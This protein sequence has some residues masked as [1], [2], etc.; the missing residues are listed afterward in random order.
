MIIDVSKWNGTINWEM[1]KGVIKGAILQCGYGDD[2][3]SQ[4]DPTFIRNATECERL[5]IP[6][7]VYLFS[8]ADSD[9]H[10]ESETDHILRMLKGRNLSYPVYIDLESEG[11]PKSSYNAN[12]F[13]KMGEKIENAGYWFGVYANEDWF[14]TTIKNSLDRFT[15]WIANY[16]RKPA[17]ACD[18]W[19]YTS[20]GNIAGVQGNL[21]CNE[22]YRDFPKEISGKVVTPSKPS[23]T[24]TPTPSVVTYTT[25]SGDS[26]S[27][28]ASKY[29][30]TWQELA[31][32]NGIANPNLIYPGQVIK[33]K[34]AASAQTYVSYTVQK[35]DSLW[36]IANKYGKSYQKI[37]SDNGIQ[38]PNVIMPGQV[39]RIY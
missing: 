6:Y 1:A 29:G 22:V 13:I 38:N 30:T 37:A 32:I 28:I 9:A 19:Q 34:G 21:D 12:R 5:G 3:A 36:A 24:P 18:I 11:I 14:Y 35:G 10:A 15:K 27:A 16:S 33:I 26:L 39:L 4:D 31:R 8:Y 7:G 23:P 25:K 2:I 20:T 17:I